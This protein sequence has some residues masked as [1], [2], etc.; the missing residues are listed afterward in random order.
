M[1]LAREFAR[2]ATARDAEFTTN[3][4]ERGIFTDLAPGRRVRGNLVAQFAARSGP[5][6]ADAVEIMHPWVDGIDLNCGW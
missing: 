1:M 3:N 6:F 5:E 4:R 2:S